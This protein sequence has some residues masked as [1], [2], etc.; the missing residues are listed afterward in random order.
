MKTDLFKSFC[1]WKGKKINYVIIHLFQFSTF[2]A[3][4]FFGGSFGYLTSRHIHRSGVF[5][6]WL[7][8]CGPLWL[9]QFLFPFSL[10][11]GNASDGSCSATLMLNARGKHSLALLLLI[12]SG[13]ICMYVCVL[14]CVWLFVTLWIVTV[15]GILQARTLEWVAMPSCRESSW[16]R[17]PTHVSCIAKRILHHWA[18][19][20]VCDIFYLA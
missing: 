16:P 15:Q 2:W 9:C 12:W 6:S 10:M 18:T 20:E 8:L 5:P 1:V 11:T 4:R 19:W 13:H 3:P 14:H 7:K 17:D